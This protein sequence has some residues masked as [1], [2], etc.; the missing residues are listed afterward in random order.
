MHGVFEGFFARYITLFV[1][2][3][4][5]GLCC[6]RLRLNQ[7]NS[8]AMNVKS[9]IENPPFKLSEDDINALLGHFEK[10]RPYDWAQL[11][12]IIGISHLATDCR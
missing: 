3:S 12:N 10:F 2:H 7:Q 5:V 1:D 4:K 6:C 11:K 8:A 9:V